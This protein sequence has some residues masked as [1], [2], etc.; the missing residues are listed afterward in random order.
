M[1]Q[2]PTEI[3][4]QKIDVV[5]IGIQSSV[6]LFVLREDLIHPHISGN[7]F[8]KL[9][10]NLLEAKNQKK[11]ML[12]TFGGAYS[13]HISAVAFAGKKYGF[14]TMGWIRG[15]ELEDKINENS[16][17]QFAKSCGMEFCFMDREL[18]RNKEK[19]EFLAELTKKFPNAYIIPEGGTN[20]LA[21]KGCE[22]IVTP[23]LKVFDRICCAVGT[24]GTIIGLI[25][26]KYPH[27]KVL[28]FPALK[29]YFGLS[30][31]IE[32]HTND[33]NYDLMVDY[34]FGGYAKITDELVSFVNDFKLHFNVPLDPIYTG[35]MLFG[36]I[37]LIKKN[38]FKE[39]DKIL[40]IHTGGLQG[41]EG[42]NQK[43]KN[44][45]RQQII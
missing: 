42:I 11:E 17:L 2:I 14:K 40:A 32:N 16:T 4:I 36:I 15:E 6:E 28:G 44:Q 25:N 39:N 23:K 41:I 21:I 45:N 12:L 27:Q 19:K 8:R 34:H 3:A 31:I 9:K 13:N 7:K 38:K 18:Y 5:K 30:A 37:D 35:K 24:G 33:K 22:E 26:A 29:N 43:L 1:I 10:Y 20:N